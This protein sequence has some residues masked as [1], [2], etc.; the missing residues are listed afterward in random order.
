MNELVTVVVPS[1]ALHD[2]RTTVLNR[3]DRVTRRGWLAEMKR[4]LLNTRGR[5]INSRPEPSLG[6]GCFSFVLFGRLRCVFSVETSVRRSW[7]WFF[8]KRPCRTITVLQC[9]LH[10]P[11]TRQ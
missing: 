10:R 11:P 8:R 1:A 2:F 5:A 6:P 7:R 3:I 4:V 9:R